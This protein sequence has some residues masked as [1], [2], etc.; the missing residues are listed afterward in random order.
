MKMKYLIINSI[1]LLF[2]VTANSQ[3]NTK[4]TEP[5]QKVESEISNTLLMNTYIKKR[6]QSSSKYSKE[7]SPNDQKEL[8]SNHCLRSSRSGRLL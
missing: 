4:K 7:I 3:E 8:P 2:A 6:K 1:F 5:K